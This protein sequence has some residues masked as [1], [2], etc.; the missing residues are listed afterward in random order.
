MALK[1]VLFRHLSRPIRYS[2]AIGGAIPLK[3]TNC[4]ENTRLLAGRVA[5]TSHFNLEE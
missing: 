4:E 5:L 2:S 1:K 3:E